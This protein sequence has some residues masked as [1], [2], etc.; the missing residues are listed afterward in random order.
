MRWDH[1]SS[2]GA[3]PA[4][5]RRA[6]RPGVLFLLEQGAVHAA[7]LPLAEEPFVTLLLES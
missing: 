2:G 1:G 6:R 4:P 5:A 3:A 7:V